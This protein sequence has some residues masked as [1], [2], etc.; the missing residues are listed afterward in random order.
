MSTNKCREIISEIKARSDESILH[1]DVRQL[2]GD[3]RTASIDAF[4]S[5]FHRAQ[6]R[7]LS[8]LP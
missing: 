4:K 5:E 2:R 1:P 8:A 3:L 7:S 6:V